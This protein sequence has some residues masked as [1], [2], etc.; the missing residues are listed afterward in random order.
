MPKQTIEKWIASKKAQ[1]YSEHPLKPTYSEWKAEQLKDVS[2]E[3]L[4]AR[5]VLLTAPANTAFAHAFW[6]LCED[7]SLPLLAE[8]A[9]VVGIDY[10]PRPRQYYPERQADGAVL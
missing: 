9:K 4:L 3:Q 5:L 10:R 2:I 7:I 6:E 1:G 8:E